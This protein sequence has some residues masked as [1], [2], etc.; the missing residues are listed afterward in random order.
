MSSAFFDI[1]LFFYFVCCLNYDLYCCNKISW[2]KESRGGKVL[3]Q[4]TIKDHSLSLTDSEKELKESSWRQMLIQRPWNID[5]FSMQLWT[6]FLIH[7]R[8]TGPGAAPP[9]S[10]INQEN[11]AQAILIRKLFQ[12]TSFF[13]RTPVCQLELELGNTVTKVIIPQQQ[14]KL[15]TRC[16]WSFWWSHSY[17]SYF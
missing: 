3:F 16:F 15:P 17:K 13:Q 1:L 8:T 11:T 2:P 5:L 10:S 7:A 14:W 4:L 9:T 12:L 6:W